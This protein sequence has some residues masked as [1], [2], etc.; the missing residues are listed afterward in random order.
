MFVF[1][2][3]NTFSRI[4]NVYNFFPP[5]HFRSYSSNSCSSVQLVSGKYLACSGLLALHLACRCV[6]VC[7]S[8][9]FHPL[10]HFIAMGQS[11]MTGGRGD[12]YVF[13]IPTTCCSGF[14]LKY[15]SIILFSCF[16]LYDFCFPFSRRSTFRPRYYLFRL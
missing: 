13:E 7:H 2:V 4:L 11:E 14:L 12:S 9:S 1:S 16:G 3:C 5:Y 15:I 8:I 6:S 10:G